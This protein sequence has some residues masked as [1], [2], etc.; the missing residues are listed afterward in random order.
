[1]GHEFFLLELLD[2]LLVHLDLLGVHSE[3]LDQGDIW[4]SQKLSQEVNEWLFEL[5][6]GFG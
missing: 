1:L 5:V 2:V 6:V 4:V 3:V